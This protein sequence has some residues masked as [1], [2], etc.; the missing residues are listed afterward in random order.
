MQHMVLSGH[1]SMQI[2]EAGET[3]SVD[4]NAM[5]IVVSGSL[6]RTLYNGADHQLQ[7]LKNEW[8]S[9]EVLGE[10]ALLTAL[11][12]DFTAECT[13]R[14]VLVEVPRHVVGM[15]LL[16]RPQFVIE[17]SR[18]VSRTNPLLVQA[19]MA[20]QRATGEPTQTTWETPGKLVN[21]IKTKVLR[22]AATSKRA[23]TFKVEMGNA[24][25]GR[26][27]DARSKQV[28]TL[29]HVFHQ[30]GYPHKHIPRTKTPALRT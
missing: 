12:P 28:C 11:D 25:A 30:V 29:I 18:N 20:F 24:T 5:Y 23:G 6:Q 16:S 13:S 2:R 26:S 15:V 22:R 1:C 9:G 4:G 10:T 7:F 3:I 8:H 17:V 27:E 21:T 14:A 19:A